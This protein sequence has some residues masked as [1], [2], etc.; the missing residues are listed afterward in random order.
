MRHAQSPG[1]PAARAR[2]RQIARRV[3]H[4][5]RATHAGAGVCAPV[6]PRAAGSCRGCVRPGAGVRRMSL[7]IR[8]IRALE[9][10]DSRGNPTVMVEVELSDATAASAK[11]PSGA[12]TG[13]H[14]AIELRDGDASHYAGKGVRKAVENVTRVILPA[15]RGAN[16]DDQGAVDRRMI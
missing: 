2:G 5:S 11:V 1:L 9:I 10:L 16:V 15:L 6:D 8:D 12:S 13:S 14:E 3:H 7:T 4:R